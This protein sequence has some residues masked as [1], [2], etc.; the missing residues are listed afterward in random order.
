MRQEM[1][2]KQSNVTIWGWTRTDK[3]H[4][5][6]SCVTLSYDGKLHSSLCP[7][8]IAM[9]PVNVSLSIYNNGS[10]NN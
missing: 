8:T 9:V 5:H 7:V 6:I 2:P 3:N 10:G 1:L 4:V